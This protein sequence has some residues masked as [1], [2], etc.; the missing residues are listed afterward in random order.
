MMLFLANQGVGLGEVPIQY[1]ARHIARAIL[2][3]DRG[4][5]GELPP[6]YPGP[7]AA[8]QGRDIPISL[9]KDAL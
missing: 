6:R 9:Q 4:C 1:V 7:A 2:L 8:A 5:A 3:P